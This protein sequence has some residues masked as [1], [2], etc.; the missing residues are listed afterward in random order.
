MIRYGMVCG[1]EGCRG[2]GKLRGLGSVIFGNETA[3]S[4]TPHQPAHLRF[5]SSSV[6]SPNRMK[7]RASGPASIVLKS[8][9]HPSTSLPLPF[10]SLSLLTRLISSSYLPLSPYSLLALLLAISFL[11]L[12]ILPTC[13]ASSNLTLPHC[14]SPPPALLS[15]FGR[16]IRLA[17]IIQLLGA[18]N[19][20][21]SS[22]DYTDR[23]PHVRVA[24]LNS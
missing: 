4:C 12:S 3:K 14:L 17:D 7:L 19:F 13:L 6:K 2:N 18:S 21:S 15:T 1:R 5:C 23:I 24:S 20:L 8:R 11:L 9:P 16:H 22:L 10:S